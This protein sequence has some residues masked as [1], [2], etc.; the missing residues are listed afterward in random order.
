MHPIVSWDDADTARDHFRRDGFVIMEPVF[1]AAQCEWARDRLAGLFEGRFPTGIFPDEWYWREGLSLPEATRH[2]AN[3]WKAD[4][5][6][7]AIVRSP[8]VGAWICF[9]NGWADACL[10]QDTIWIKPPEARAS[11][12][13]QDNSFIDYLRPASMSTC[14]MTFDDT[15]ADAATLEYV[16]GSHRWPTTELPADFHDPGNDHRARMRAAAAAAGIT[17]PD[18]VQLVVPAGTVVFHDGNV[19][20]GAGPSLR[21]ASWRHTLAAHL[22]PGETRFAGSAG[23]YIYRRYQL[24][25]DDTLHDAFFPRYPRSTGVPVV[26]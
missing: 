14:W 21:T 18:V 1:S 26:P 15:H 5:E 9:L 20:H 22:V 8:W 17:P 25:G 19:W 6:I 4:P 13:H 24:P 16:P 2:M 12:L 10:G 23:G 3:A 7:A 11:A